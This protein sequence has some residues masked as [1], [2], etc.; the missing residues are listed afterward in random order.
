MTK[1]VIFDLGKVLVPF[2]FTRGYDQI[3]AL[4]GLSHDEI[5]ERLRS[6]GV[7]VA[8]E[9]GQIEPEAFVSEVGRLLGVQIGYERF[10]EIW[11]SIFLPETLIPEAMVET[12]RRQRRTLLLSNTNAIHF[13]MLRRQYRILDHFDGF[14]LSH[15]VRALKPD[16]RIYRRAIEMAGC[17]PE[18]CFFTD[19]ISDYVEGARK[20]GIDAVQFQHA[21]QIAS[22]LR[23]RGIE[24]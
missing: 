6:A 3:S 13:D 9:S 22:E 12:I 2:D 5:R 7:V 15:E 4:S 19:D 18:E 11:S 16:P 24:C 8:L 20:A 23:R 21:S 10:C 17:E 14:V 1:T